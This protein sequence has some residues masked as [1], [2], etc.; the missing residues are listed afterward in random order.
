MGGKLYAVA[1]SI[2]HQGY[3]EKSMVHDIAL[4]LLAQPVVLN[5]KV[6]VIPLS[7]AIIGASAPLIL[8]GWGK[9]S[10]KSHEIYWISTM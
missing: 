9:I 6:R 8:T 1:K 7:N 10:V 2:P 4:L 5:D 3:S